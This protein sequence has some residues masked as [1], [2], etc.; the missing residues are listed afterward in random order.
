MIVRFS[1]NSPSGMCPGKTVAARGRVNRR[2]E[3]EQRKL[4]CSAEPLGG[5]EG[6]ARG[7]AKLVWT[8]PSRDRGKAEGLTGGASSRQAVG[9]M[10]EA[11]FCGAHT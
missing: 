7:E 10:S 8:I 3:R 4:A 5:A 11:K 1:Y 2:R 6:A 9:G